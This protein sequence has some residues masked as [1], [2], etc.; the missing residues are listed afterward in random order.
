LGGGVV[1]FLFVFL[2]QHH[3]HISYITGKECKTFTHE[4]LLAFLHLASDSIQVFRSLMH[5]K[6]ARNVPQHKF[7]NLLKTLGEFGVAFSGGREYLA[8]LILK[9]ELCR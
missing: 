6:I 9:W 1:E 2:F 7:R 8:S 3:V 5:P 4:P